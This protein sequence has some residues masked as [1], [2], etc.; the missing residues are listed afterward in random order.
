MQDLEVFYVSE[1]NHFA[2]HCIFDLG[3]VSGDFLNVKQ[4]LTL[5]AAASE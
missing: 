2:E 4:K 5:S 3:D 1:D